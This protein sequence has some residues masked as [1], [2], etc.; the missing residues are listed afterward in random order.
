MAEMRL[1]D[2]RVLAYNQYGAA[3]GRPLF[4]FHGGMSNSKD[5][6]FA[7][8]YCKSAGLLI[9]A[10]DRPGTGK[11]TRLKGRRVLDWPDDV[12]DLADHLDIKQAPVMGWSIA[13]ASALACGYKHPERFP[14][15]ITVASSGPVLDDAGI[16][17]LGLLGDRLLLRSPRWMDRPWSMIFK[18][19]SYLPHGFLKSQILGELLN[20]PDA[21]ILSAL[22]DDTV[23]GY[24]KGAVSENGYGIIDDYRAVEGPWGFA[25]G[26]IQSDVRMWHGE[27]DIVCPLAIAHRLQSEMPRAQLTVVPDSGH[28]LLH[29]NFELILSQADLTADA[30]D[31]QSHGQR[32]R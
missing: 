3:D 13:G 23:G 5:I 9:I 28:F 24:F 31:A 14:R 7:H 10:P 27:K 2:G 6:A 8:E 17:E 26:E 22:P 18:I 16:R 15:V 20:T 29:R 21:D 1:R 12:A 11:S 32:Q 19:S 25:L 4:Y 30:G